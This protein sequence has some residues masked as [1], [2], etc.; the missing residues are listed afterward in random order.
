MEPISRLWTA[1]KNL[2]GYGLDFY[3]RVGK[4]L[5]SVQILTE[6]DRDSF[7]ALAGAYHLMMLCQDEINEQ[8]ANVRGSQDEIKKNPALTSYKSASDIFNRLSRRFYLTPL[9]R[10]GVTIEKPKPKNGKEKFFQ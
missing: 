3:K 7:C 6:L 4:Q 2:Q 9:D 5:V 10:A 1:P 8:G